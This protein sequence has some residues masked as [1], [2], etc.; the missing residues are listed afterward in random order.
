MNK[1]RAAAIWKMLAD[2]SADP[3][4]DIYVPIPILRA[5]EFG[6]IDRWECWAALY[7]SGAR[8]RDL[9]GFL[10]HSPPR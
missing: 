4:D 5:Y 9:N 8:G 1:E 7:N 3:N 2:A 10:H 6:I